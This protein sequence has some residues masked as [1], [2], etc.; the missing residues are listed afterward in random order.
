[1]TVQSFI[2]DCLLSVVY[3]VGA[4]AALVAGTVSAPIDALQY[5]DRK[6]VYPWIILWAGILVLILSL[7]SSSQSKQLGWRQTSIFWSKKGESCD[8]ACGPKLQCNTPLVDEATTSNYGNNESSLQIKQF[9]KIFPSLAKACPNMITSN[10]PAGFTQLTE[11]AEHG[12]EIILHN[13]LNG[14]CKFS[15]P[16][17]SM[18]CTCL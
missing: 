10:D 2:T 14:S 13:F 16:N 15:H 18:A 11:S 17:A 4:F 9:K 7:R 3:S 6:D 8:D 12:C 1:M 5:S